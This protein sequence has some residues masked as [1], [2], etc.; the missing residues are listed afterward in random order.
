MA[1]PY[2]IV[3]DDETSFVVEQPST[4]SAPS[5]TYTALPPG[6]HFRLLTVLPGAPNTKLKC[7]LT[8]HALDS[9][10]TPPYKALSYCWNNPKFDSLVINNKPIPHDDPLRTDYTVCH[11]LW[12]VGDSDT[13][14]SQRRILISTSLRDALRKLRSRTEPVRLWVDAL[15]INQGDNAEKGVQ[16]LLMQRIYHAAAEVCMW[17]GAGDADGA[18]CNA[19]EMLRMLDKV[20]KAKPRPEVSQGD[21]Y[22]QQVL[23]DLGFPPFP[24]RSWSDL[25]HFFRRPYFRRIWILQEMIA[26]SLSSRLY[27]G[28]LEP[29]PWTTLVGAV[30]FLQRA[31]WIP[32]LS[33]QYDPENNIS[34][35]LTTVSIGIAW[36][37][38]AETEQDRHQIRRR[39]LNTRRFEASDPKDKIFALIGII[40]DFG[41]RDLLGEDSPEGSGYGPP[42]TVIKSGTVHATFKVDERG[43]SKEDIAIEILKSNPAEE[44]QQLHA[45]LLDV[46]RG[47]VRMA[48]ILLH[49]DEDYTSPEF[50]ADY[51]QTTQHTIDGLT[52]IP[53]FNKDCRRLSL[54][55]QRVGDF[56]SNLLKMFSSSIQLYAGFI[57]EYCEDELFARLCRVPVFLEEVL[58]F[59]KGASFMLESMEH[60]CTCTSNSATPDPNS[61]PPAGSSNNARVQD[62]MPI[63]I[64]SRAHLDSLEYSVKFS[65]QYQD[66]AWSACGWI[67][68]M[69]DLPVEDVYTEY[70]AKC[71]QDDGDLDI[72]SAIEDRSA[73]RLHGLPSWVP[74]FSVPMVRWPLAATGI[75]DRA[76]GC[77]YSASGR[78]S[79]ARPKWSKQQAGGREIVLGGF[80]FD[81]IAAISSREEA[82]DRKMGGGR[83]LREWEAMID[84]LPEDHAYHGECSASEAL[85]RTLIGD[86]DAQ[87]RSPAPGEYEARYETFRKLVRLDEEIGARLES[88]QDPDA[89]RTA[90]LGEYNIQPDELPRL[91]AEHGMFLRS[92]TEVMLDRR[93]FVTE[94]GY[95]GAGPLSAEVGDSV[96]VLAGG[97]VPLVL[98]RR[99]EGDGD[100][101]FQFA[102]VGDCYVHGIMQGEALGEALESE[103]FCWT[104]IRLR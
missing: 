70:T 19:L 9:P 65:R 63:L 73:R 104:D 6:N 80:E 21:I 26:A 38:G 8:I 35:V 16:L 77:C 92:V 100:E 11:A 13:G 46:L 58:R 27:C 67:M 20:G 98:R 69:Y 34:F 48:D 39:T 24:S 93:L 43:K 53:T 50:L 1:K 81:R 45:A 57:G 22:N 91:S 75:I 29:V 62:N 3:A 40:N 68:P 32:R 54:D 87:G 97:H 89:A 52:Y 76:E 18:A 17:L 44:I 30:A 85:W 74:D 49:P 61:D 36:A 90:V 60:A 84:Q 37:Q 31:D 5:Y 47:C 23:V 41:H 95:I 94:E 83:K 15:C 64:G 79:K 59:Q 2:A 14:E 42:Q 103:V 88:G 72:L 102:V 101:S 7:T 71:I 28:E 10:D 96:Y 25:M 12:C 78:S 51:A 56:A 86:R 33:A 66:W 82:A 4:S 55:H 99:V